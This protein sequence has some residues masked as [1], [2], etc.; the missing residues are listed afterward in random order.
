M[1]NK[2]SHSLEIGSYDWL[3]AKCIEGDC[4]AFRNL[5]KKSRSRAIENCLRRSGNDDA[6]SIKLKIF[7]SIFD[8]ECPN[9]NS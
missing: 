6:E 9:K 1:A 5:C 4:Q 8:G 2:K 3:V 7:Q